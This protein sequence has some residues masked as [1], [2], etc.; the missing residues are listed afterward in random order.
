MTKSLRNSKLKHE[1]KNKVKD[2]DQLEG[3]DE[4]NLSAV[5]KV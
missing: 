3:E 4:E 5:K 2:K 1:L